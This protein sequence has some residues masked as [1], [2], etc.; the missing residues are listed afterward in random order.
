[1]TTWIARG[2]WNGNFGSPKPIVLTGNVEILETRWRYIE[3]SVW[4]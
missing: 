2:P 1:M 4:T 3:T